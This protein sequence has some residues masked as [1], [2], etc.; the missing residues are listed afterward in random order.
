MAKNRQR[1]LVWLLLFV[2]VITVIGFVL[3]RNLC[4]GR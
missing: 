3:S 1:K 2:L 4:S